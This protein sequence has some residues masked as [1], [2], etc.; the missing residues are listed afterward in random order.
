MNEYV[1]DMW[2]D[3]K[4]SIWVLTAIFMFRFCIY[5]VG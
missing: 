4:L 1:G 3:M 2:D 5:E